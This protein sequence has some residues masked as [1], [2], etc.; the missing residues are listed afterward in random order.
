[1]QELIDKV[2]ELVAF[3]LERA[4]TIHPPKF[5]SYHEAYAVTE[6][7]MDECEDEW[8]KACAALECAWSRIKDDSKPIEVNHW[9]EIAERYFINAIAEATQCAAMCRKARMNEPETHDTR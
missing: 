8:E 7:E 6:E 1:M 9:L 5:N 3:E 4:N 2:Q